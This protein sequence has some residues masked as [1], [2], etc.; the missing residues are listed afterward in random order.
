M[1]SR[2]WVG[3]SGTWD[4]TT[5]THWS[6]TSGGSGGASVPTS[7]DNVFFDSNSGSAV[8]SDGSGGMVALNLDCTNFTGSLN[9]GNGPNGLAIYGSLFLSAAMTF[10]YPYTMSFLATATGKTITTNGHTIDGGH[11]GQF[12]FNGIG[13]GW[14]LQD[15]FLS[16]GVLVIQN[17]TLNTNGQNVTLSGLIASNGTSSLILGSSL[18]VIT[19]NDSFQTTFNL[20]AT[21][22]SFSSNTSTIKFTDITANAISF[23]GNSLTYNN[24]WFSRG[25]STAAITVK[26][27]NIF[28]GFKDDGT[29]THSL[30]FTAATTQTITSWNVSGIASHPITLNSTTTAI[31]TLSIASGIVSSDYLNIQHCVATG[32]ASWF[33]G[34]NSTNNQGVA[35][36]G[37]GWIFTAPPGGNM[38][39]GIM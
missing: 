39:F 11:L 24:V 8:I 36:A 35:T 13:G 9:F 29:G 31:F 2:F 4:S 17:G 26:G 27:S 30:I 32:G 37:S 20:T 7:S 34:A 33:A 18:V 3:G 28:N 14:T 23:N 12:L 10:N 6:T 5:T 15:S 19:G 1:A 25:I 21:G 16:D 38:F 22:F